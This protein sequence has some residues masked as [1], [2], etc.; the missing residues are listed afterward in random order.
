MAPFCEYYRQKD[1]IE[2]WREGV[3]ALNIAFACQC[4]TELHVL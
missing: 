3:I 4:F 1:Q 2:H